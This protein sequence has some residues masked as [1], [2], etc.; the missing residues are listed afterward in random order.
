MTIERRIQ[1]RQRAARR[2]VGDMV[3]RAREDEGVSIRALGRAAGLDPSHLARAER[4]E[5]ALSQDALV[6]L[7]TALGRDV[8]WRLYETG[9][10]LVRD[11]L[12]LPM[13][14]AL[15][16][17]LHGRWRPPRLEVQVTRPARGVI[18][19][20]LQD[21][22]TADIVATEG[23]SLLHSVEAQLRWAGAKAD[24][25]PS[26]RGWPWTD[27]VSEPRI[28][29]LLLLRSCEAT[30]HVVGSYPSLFAAAYP[31]PPD[32]AYAALAGGTDPWP[33]SAILWVRVENGR[34]HVLEGPPRA[35]KRR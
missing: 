26:A 27:R 18:D 22:L 13:F 30:H 7:A 19:A 34:G 10:P 3:R 12:S 2:A 16:S 23:H 5:H 1:E 14:D 4:G 11:R 8:S 33:G 21:R 15:L 28:G 35:L 32:Q 31:A 29:R 6:A 25:L 17:I 9:S 20:V 24:S